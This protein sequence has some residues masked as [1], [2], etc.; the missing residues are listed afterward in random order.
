LL[1]YGIH[2]HLRFRNNRIAI[3]RIPTK[4]HDTVA[5][6]SDDG[7]DE[8]PRDDN[9]FAGDKQRLI[10]RDAIGQKLLVISG[11]AGILAFLINIEMEFPF[12]KLEI[13]TRRR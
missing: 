2:C 5:P 7:I 1:G 6:A 12:F 13:Q 10:A 3:W 8:A 9:L 11:G 4:R